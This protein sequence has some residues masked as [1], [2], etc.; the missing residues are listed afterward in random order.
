MPHN[1]SPFSF[2]FSPSPAA[3]HY[4]PTLSVWLSVDPMSDKYPGVSPYVYCANNP[5]K[6]VDPDGREIWIHT[7]KG[8]FQ[9]INGS[10]M[11]KDGTE[12]TGKIRGFAKSALNALIVLNKTAMGGEL[13]GELQNS[14]IKYTISKSDH[15]NKYNTISKTISWNPRGI[16]LPTTAS[17]YGNGYRCAVADMGHELSHAY[18]DNFNMLDFSS[19]ERDGESLSNNEWLAVYRENLIREELGKPYRTHYVA[20]REENTKFFIGGSGPFMLDADGCPYLPFPYPEKR[21]HNE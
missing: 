19:S 9:Y 14:E 11:K 3:R 21:N 15:L 10:L 2:Q 5:V 20:K 18:D 6:L 8:D 7:R 1:L 13:V 16:E 17:S 4:H 12:Y